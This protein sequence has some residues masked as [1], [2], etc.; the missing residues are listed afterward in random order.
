MRRYEWVGLHYF[1][2]DLFFKQ[3][4]EE[5]N[6][7]DRQLPFYTIPGLS[8]RKL[9]QDKD[10]ILERHVRTTSNKLKMLYND[11]QAKGDL[12]NDMLSFTSCGLLCGK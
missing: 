12:F 4:A 1:H 5:E 10:K 9:L 3:V 11:K 7:Q 6:H 8:L 2:P